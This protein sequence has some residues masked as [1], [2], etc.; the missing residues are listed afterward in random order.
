MGCSNSSAVVNPKDK[1]SAPVVLQISTAHYLSVSK[2]EPRS[3]M[4][5]LT[6]TMIQTPSAKSNVL[7][8]TEEQGGR[9]WSTLPA[10][11]KKRLETVFPGRKVEKIFVGQ[12][13][14]APAASL[15]D[16]FTHKIPNATVENLSI[17]G[18]Y[19]R[20][21]SIC[22][23][24][25]QLAQ[26][27]LIGVNLPLRDF[28]SSLGEYTPVRAKYQRDTASTIVKEA[29]SPIIESPLLPDKTYTRELPTR[30]G[31]TIHDP[32]T[33]K[34][35]IRRRLASEVNILDKIR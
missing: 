25:A 33:S 12:S 10:L 3:E 17:Q 11:N 18:E 15:D 6:D 24:H 14:H 35:V 4:I 34:Y 26:A 32:T 9:H 1:T 20:C 27:P 13:F 23:S 29:G 8:K 2:P 5:A 22:F 28:G 19:N 31:G 21:G 7:M 16:F 30:A